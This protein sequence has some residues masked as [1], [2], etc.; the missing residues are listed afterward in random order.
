MQTFKHSNRFT[1]GKRE[2]EGKPHRQTCL[3]VNHV[4]LRRHQQTSKPANHPTYYSSGND[5]QINKDKFTTKEEQSR[6]Q[7]IR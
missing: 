4:N 1:Q 5:V 6:T 2:N 7:K 3:D